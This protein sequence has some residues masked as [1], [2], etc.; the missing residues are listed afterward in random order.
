MLTKLLEGVSSKLADQWVATLLTPAFIFWAGGLLAYVHR[1]SFTPIETW[2]Q[3]F[4]NPLQL[5]LI[6]IALCIVTA[7]AFVA[8]RFDTAVLRGLEGYWYPGLR[9]LSKPLLHWQKVRRRRLK[10]TLNQLYPEVENNT[11]TAAKRAKFAQCDLALRQLPTQEDD[12]LPT[13]LGNIL[14]AAERR[15]HDRYGLDAIICWP[16]L[17]LLLPEAVR[18]DF[19]AAQAELNNAVRLVF[20]GGLLCVWGIWAWWAIPIGL[21]AAYVAYGWAVDAAAVHASLIEAT[22]D[23]H[24]HLLYK[25]LRRKLPV[26]PSTEKHEGKALTEYL[27]RGPDDNMPD[28][29]DPPKS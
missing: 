16:H 7:S 10:A 22:F 2:F 4:S 23:L 3:Q 12:L 6:V 17:W 1:Y 11:A 14:R 21:V 19:Q 25:A 27:W 9:R 29:Y 15:P 5:G 13:R 24:R 18:K 20:W 8:Q 28:F 26:N